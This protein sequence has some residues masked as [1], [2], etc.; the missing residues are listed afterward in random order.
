[1]DTNVLALEIEFDVTNMGPLY[2]LLGVKFIKLDSIELAQEA[3]I[4]KILESGQMNDSHPTLRP[5][6]P[7]TRITK[8]ESVLEGEH[9]L[10]S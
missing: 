7:N 1:M 6:D 4:N 5:I 10:L 3:L 2:W 8:E 9:H